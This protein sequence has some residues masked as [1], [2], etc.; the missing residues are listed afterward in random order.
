MLI[1]LLVPFSSGQAGAN[2]VAWSY[3]AINWVTASGLFAYQ[4]RRY[5]AIRFWEVMQYLGLMIVLC[6][7]VAL[8]AIAIRTVFKLLYV[9]VKSTM[10]LLEVS[11]ISIFSI[12]V[13]YRI[14]RWLNIGATLEILKYVRLLV[15]KFK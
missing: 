5:R 12:V 1:T 7:G 13:A 3:I 2:G 14:S 11:V 9:Q 4:V 10:L 15:E 6:L 8:T